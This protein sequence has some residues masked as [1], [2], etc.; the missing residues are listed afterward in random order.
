MFSDPQNYDLDFLTQFAPNVTTNSGL[1]TRSNLAVTEDSRIF[2]AV[3]PDIPT[4]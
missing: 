4:S 2:A 1:I 3:L